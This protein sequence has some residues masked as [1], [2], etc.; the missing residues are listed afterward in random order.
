[1]SPSIS[2]PHDEFTVLEYIKEANAA[3]IANKIRAITVI[4]LFVFIIATLLSLCP[5]RTSH[6]DFASYVV[7]ASGVTDNQPKA[8]ACRVFPLRLGW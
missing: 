4:V 6:V 8:T 5:I 2:R 3:T 7:H 1:M